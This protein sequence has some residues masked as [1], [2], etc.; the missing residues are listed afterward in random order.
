[1]PDL[2]SPHRKRRGTKSS[3]NDTPHAETTAAPLVAVG[4]TESRMLDAARRVFIRRGTAGARMQ[5][6]AAEAGVNQALVHYYFGSKSALA[7]R[8]FLD[9]AAGVFRALAPVP[10]PTATLEQTLER[11]VAGYIDAVRRTPFVP[12]Y[13]LAESHQHPERLNALMQKAVGFNPATLAALTLSR[14]E[15]MIA[16]RVAAGLMRPMSARQF[17]V[18]VMSLVVFPFVGRPVLMMAFGFSDE[19]FDEFLDERRREL[20]GFI[21]NALRP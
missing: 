6:I 10:D 2:P 18:N 14:V 9:A 8:V 15:A 12:A 4:D 13:L 7:E 5:E 3:L 17:L 21:L 16:Q 20:P 1:M 19:S 11:F